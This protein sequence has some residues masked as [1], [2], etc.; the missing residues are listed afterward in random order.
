MIARKNYST[1]SYDNK[2]DP[3]KLQDIFSALERLEQ[4]END[5]VCRVSLGNKVT[6]LD[7]ETEE[8]SSFFVVEPNTSDPK[9][10]RISYLSPLGSQLIGR[11]LD[12]FIEIRIFFRTDR[13]RITN[14]E[15]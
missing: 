5:D 14:I 4:R 10:A 8:V 6:L 13:F 11:K 15:R 7:T 1:K 3:I 12:D 9:S 2:L